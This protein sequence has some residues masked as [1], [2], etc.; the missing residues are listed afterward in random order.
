MN[1]IERIKEWLED[2]LVIE[3]KED[4][5]S[6]LDSKDIREMLEWKY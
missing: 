3:Y 5:K 2:I 4:R 6:K 1:K